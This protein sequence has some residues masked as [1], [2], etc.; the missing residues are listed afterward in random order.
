VGRNIEVMQLLAQ[1]SPVHL[2]MPTGVYREA[3]LPVAYHDISLESLADLFIS[4][5]ND[6]IEGTAVR[7][8]FIKLAVSEE[9]ITPRERR[10]LQA[11]ALASQQTGAVIASHTIGGKL[12][13]QEMDILEAAGLKMDRFIW[14]H[15][16]TEPDQSIHLEAA[17]RGAWIELDA[18]GVPEQMEIHLNATI[19]LIQAGYSGSIL[20]SHDAGWYQPG[21]QGGVLPDQE[22]RGYTSLVNEFLPALRRR[23]I[24]EDLIRKLTVTN[25]ARAFAF[26]QPAG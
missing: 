20:L 11:A 24:S 7:A 1:S 2:V 6:G 14:V 25:P 4:E 23:G 9:G 22:I 26:G 18:I 13:Q 15:A 19:A 10:N 16:Q 5:L 8:G 17:Q 21:Q 12:A 3:F